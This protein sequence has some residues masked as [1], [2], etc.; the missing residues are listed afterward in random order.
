M[1]VNI[2]N[3]KMPFWQSLVLV[4][5]KNVVMHD[6]SLSSRRTEASK[7]EEVHIRVRVAFWFYI[8]WIIWLQEED[9]AWMSKE[10]EK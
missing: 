7:E 8:M 5:I 9:A 3:R 1:F 6:A 4:S 10:I 2:L